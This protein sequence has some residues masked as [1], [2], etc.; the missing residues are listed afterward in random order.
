MSRSCWAASIVILDGTDNFETR[1]LVN[2]FAV[3]Q[4]MPWIYAAAV[5]SY[6]LTMTVRPGVTACLACLLAGERE[7]AG[8]DE[9]CDTSACLGRS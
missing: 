5:G 6:G 3:K 9:T 4:S 1:F 2:D 8:M 7:G